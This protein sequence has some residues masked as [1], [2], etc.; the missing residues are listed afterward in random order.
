MKC[1]KEDNFSCSE[2]LAGLEG[3]LTRHCLAVRAAWLRATPGSQV[4]WMPTLPFS[5]T[6]GE[7][8]GQKLHSLQL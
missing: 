1:D 2:V 5:V 6:I 8:F 7:S 3:T 4:N